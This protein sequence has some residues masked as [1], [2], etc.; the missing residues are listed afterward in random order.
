VPGA[1]VARHDGLELN[2]L[3]KALDL[4]EMDPYALKDEKP[5]RLSSDHA[6]TKNGRKGLPQSDG[7]VHLHESIATL[8]LPR[9]I[10][11]LVGDQMG[12]RPTFFSKLQPTL[13]DSEIGVRLDQF[14]LILRPEAFA[15]L[16]RTLGGAIDRLQLKI[17]TRLL[18]C[19]HPS[20]TFEGHLRLLTV[21]VSSAAPGS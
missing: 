15:D 16:E 3:A 9:E 14:S 1:V 4:I 17:A 2:E 6:D 12:S 19:R 21:A 5:A 8:S 13:R 20:C 7:I 18:H 11:A 10:W